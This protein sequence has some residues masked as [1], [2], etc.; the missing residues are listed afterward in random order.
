MYQEKRPTCVTV[1]GWAWIIIGAL[2]C[3]SAVMGLFTSVMIRQVSTAHPDAHRNMPGLFRFFPMVALVQIGVA[4]FGIVSG[5]SFLK[6]RAWSRNALEVLTWLLLLFVA[7]FM[8]FWVVNWFSITSRRDLDAFSIIGAVMGVVASTV[9]GIPL[10]IML[11]FLRGD[12]VKTAIV[13]ASQPSGGNAAPP[14]AST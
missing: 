6:L 5:I 12:K 11:K 10:G 8:V 9:Y 4:V 3:F 1:I 14:C 7:G 2:M 13:I